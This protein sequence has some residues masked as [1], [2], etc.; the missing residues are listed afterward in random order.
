MWFPSKCW[1]FLLMQKFW[2]KFITF[3]KIES[4]WI[5]QNQ[6]LELLSSSVF[7]TF[8]S[9]SQSSTS[10]TLS[11]NEFVFLKT[12][13][14]DSTTG[15]FT[16]QWECAVMPQPNN[17]RGF[18]VLNKLLGCF[19][20]VLSVI[21]LRESFYRTVRNILCHQNIGGIV[22]KILSRQHL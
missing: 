11:R 8:G 18:H 2:P 16:L 9:F 7:S 10:V 20:L 17:G 14:T 22:W 4:K 21:E 3:L 12:A 15:L 5:S 19:D 1:T 6:Y 13:A